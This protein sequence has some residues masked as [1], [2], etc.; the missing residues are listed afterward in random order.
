MLRPGRLIVLAAALLV[1]GC[2]GQL[3]RLRVDRADAEL[4]ALVDSDAAGQLLADLL[5]RRS[6]DQ[7]LASVESGPHSTDVV[8][9]RDPKADR[10][11]DQ[12]RLR[13]LGQEVSVD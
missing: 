8:E 10:L 4:A 1:L 6:H 7:R 3:E 2:A 13:E 5:A 9:G 12:E 11:L